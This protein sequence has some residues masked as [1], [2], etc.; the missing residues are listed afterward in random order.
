M[1]T[2]S[3]EELLIK[4]IKTIAAFNR[5]ESLTASEYRDT[6]SDAES[7]VALV[8]FDEDQSIG[9]TPQLVVEEVYLVA[10]ITRK[11]GTDSSMTPHSLCESVRSLIH[12]QQFGETDIMPFQYARRKLISYEGDTIAWEVSFKTKKHLYIPA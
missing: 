9:V 11:K 4:E 2:K 1:T 3:V 8:A 10:V 6:L 12:G 7:A 5:V